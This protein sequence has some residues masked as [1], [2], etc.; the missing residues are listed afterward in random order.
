MTMSFFRYPGGKAK[1]SKQIVE[2]LVAQGDEATEYREPFF[3][4]GGIGLQVL[5]K[6][7]PTEIKE[8]G[9]DGKKHI[10]IKPPELKITKIWINDL[11]V[12]VASLWTS[13]IRHPE[14][15][16][17][18]IRDFTPSQDAFDKFKKELQLHKPMDKRPSQVIDCGFKKL[19]IHQISYSGLGTRS[20]GPLGGRSPENVANRGST[21][22]VKYPIDCRWSEKYVCKKIDSLHAFLGKFS[23]NDEACTACDFEDLLKDSGKSLIYLDPPYYEK[24]NVLYEHGFSEEDH[25]RLSNSLSRTKGSWLLSYDD[26]LRVR[27]LYSWASLNVVQVKYSITALKETDVEGKRKSREKPELLIERGKDATTNTLLH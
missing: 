20:G 14:E 6:T 22:A 12:G 17:D 26:C 5:A 18:R 24:G 13:V 9:A 3:G 19:A 11:D 2:R 16:K 7:Q 23:I 10:T 8:N 1:L 15:L 25:M 21:T 4:G 27:E